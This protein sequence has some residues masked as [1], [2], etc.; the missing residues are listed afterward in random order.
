MVSRFWVYE[1][2]IPLQL[3]I[4]DQLIKAT[5]VLHSWLEQ[6]T[7]SIFPGVTDGILD[8]DDWEEGRIIPG[9][10]RQMKAAG[11]KATF[12]HSN[13]YGRNARDVRDNYAKIFCSSEV[14]P[15]QLMMI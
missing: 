12:L 15:W 10:W 8:V 2:P 13:N 4:A 14:V 1:K 5:C 11:M 6:R 3:H 7:T 9:C